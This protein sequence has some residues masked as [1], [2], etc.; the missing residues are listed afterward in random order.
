MDEYVGFDE[1]EIENI[2][3]GGGIEYGKHEGRKIFRKQKLHS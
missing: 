2:S 1:V 3:A